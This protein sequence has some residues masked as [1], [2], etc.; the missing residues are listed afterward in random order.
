MS[1]YFFTLI[2]KEVKKVLYC[3][4]RISLPKLLLKVAMPTGMKKSRE[5]A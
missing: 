3:N 1:Q 4:K 5:V 2:T